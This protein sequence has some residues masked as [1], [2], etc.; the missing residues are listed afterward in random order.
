MQ[1]HHSRPFVFLLC[2]LDPFVTVSVCAAFLFFHF[3]IGASKALCS[4]TI[5]LS[6]MLLKVGPCGIPSLTFHFV[7][8]S[9]EALFV[10]SLFTLCVCVCVRVRVCCTLDN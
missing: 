9:L 10:H 3:T 5:L 6:A 2:L 7:L 1:G 8:N 4:W